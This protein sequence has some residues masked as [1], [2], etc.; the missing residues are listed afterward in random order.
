MSLHTN[1]TTSASPLTAP[2]N[3]VSLPPPE[4]SPL[5]S[6][7]SE[8]G[9]PGSESGRLA[10]DLRR[11]LL[12]DGSKRAGDVGGT[13]FGWC[14]VRGGGECC[15]WADGGEQEESRTGVG[16]FA[17]SAAAGDFAAAGNEFF[18]FPHPAPPPELDR[19][20]TKSALASPGNIQVTS[21]AA[22]V[23]N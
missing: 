14:L 13:H 1:T 6:V 15:C 5:R 18:R 16:Q 3:V 4:P 23:G 21:Q 17:G 22:M 12:Q 10:R 19:R 20:R 2:C 11:L 8:R 9:S 7:H